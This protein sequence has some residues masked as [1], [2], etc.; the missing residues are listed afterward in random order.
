MKFSCFSLALLLTIGGSDGQ[1]ASAAYA[2]QN[3]PTAAVFEQQRQVPNHPTA[4]AFEQPRQA[5]S[6]ASAVHLLNRLSFG[7]RAGDI[8]RVKSMGIQGYIEQQLNP[9]TLPES[10]V[11]QNLEAN[12]STNRVS[13]EELIADFRSL[14]KQINQVRKQ[15]GDQ[16]DKGESG[17]LK[18]L[19]G[20]YKNL[21]DHD[22]EI[23]LA[24]CI[25]SPKQ[26]QEVMTEFWFNHFNVVLNKG[27]DNILVEAYE[28]QAI[29]PN[30]LGRFRDLVEA[31]C[32]HPAMLFYLDNWENTAPNS[33]E[34]HGK[35]LNENYA[36]E[37]MELHTLGVDGGYTQRDV[38]E[39][40][41]VLTGLSLAPQGPQRQKPMHMGGRRGMFMEQMQMRNQMQNQMQRVDN[42]GAYFYPG[43]HDF[44]T[45]T[46]LGYRVSGQ[47][48]AEIEECIDMLVRNP[49]TAHHIS[50]QLCQYFVCDNPPASLVNKVAGRFQQTDGD[51]KSV[52][53]ELFYSPEFWD[54]KYENA[55]YKTPLRYAVSAVRAT[56]V[57]ISNYGPINQFLRL[58]GQP[59]YGCITPDGYKNTKDAWLN[60]DSLIRRINFATSLGAGR[61]AGEQ[62]EAPE[63][64][65]L[66]ATI[67]DG[68][69]TERTVSVVAKSPDSLK[70]AVVLGSPEFM[71]Y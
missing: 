14:Q 35:G 4:A 69:F 21:R 36:R 2:E 11:V 34:A 62:L 45:K 13:N 50:Y 37:L 54:P 53:R 33:P 67:S 15:E 68:V 43:R 26:L 64:R 56:G 16:A 61:W 71:H 41:R 19:T 51:I 24:R 66:G 63:Y 8:D 18:Q 49:A 9:Q 20:V 55:K 12:S 28:N 57:Q 39:L 47:G 27:I 7:P 58:Q 6:S 5:V 30:S 59:L 29:R 17:K 25:E 10:P 1:L 44:G 22:M 65:T 52:L 70:S 32:H 48:E 60:P 3:G 38:T 31:T 42:F 46:I 40:A 23:K